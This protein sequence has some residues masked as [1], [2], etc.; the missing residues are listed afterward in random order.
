MAKF[1][2]TNFYMNIRLKDGLPMEF[3]V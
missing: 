3:I 2:E 1:Y